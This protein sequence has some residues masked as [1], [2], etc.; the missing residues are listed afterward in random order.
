M[1]PSN[2]WFTLILIASALLLNGV[3]SARAAESKNHRAQHHQADPAPQTKPVKNEEPEVPLAVWQATVSALRESI[4]DNKQQAIAAQKEAEA[5]KQTFCSPAVV[6]NEILATVGIC[7]LILMYLQ[8]SAI[9][10]QARISRATLAANRIAIGVARASANAAKDQ[11]EAAQAQVT[12]LEKTLAATEKA[13]GAA[14]KNADAAL[15]ASAAYLDITS[16]WLETEE[17]G[18][19]VMDS[20]V[21]VVDPLVH[22]KLTNYG[23]SPAMVT[24]LCWQKFFGLR[25][26]DIPIYDNCTPQPREYVIGAEKEENLSHKWSFLFGTYLTEDDMEPVRKTESRLQVYGYV[27]YRDVFDRRI[28]IGYAFR[29]DAKGNPSL[30]SDEEAAIYLYRRFE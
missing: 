15:A 23:K 24:E 13:A 22:W 20:G 7:Y 8:W 21:G 30:V 27:R 11:A 2:T 25:L 19:D 17:E 12:N 9:D 14:V 10:E 29:L 6:V 5:N 18:S 28:I 26:P 1:K 3:K 16:F 4:A